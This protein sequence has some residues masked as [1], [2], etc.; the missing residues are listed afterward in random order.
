MKK[1]NLVLA[2]VA[3]VLGGCSL[4][5]H[6]R[7]TVP[8]GDAEGPGRG[9]GPRLRG[10]GHHHFPH[11]ERRTLSPA[12][13]LNGMKTEAASES[14]TPPRSA[15]AEGRRHRPAAAYQRAMRSPTVSPSGR[16][17]RSMRLECAPFAS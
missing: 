11:R 15:A 8:E 2:G 14:R 16:V 3:L 12:Q 7:M 1:L 9:K 5:P 17:M 10:Q 6:M 13:A 4:G